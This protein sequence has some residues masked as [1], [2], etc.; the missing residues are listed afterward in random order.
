MTLWTPPVDDL[1]FVLEEVVGLDRLAALPGLSETTA[2]LA[3]AVLGEAGRFAADVL[4]PLN[5]AGDRSPPVLEAG[6]VRASPGFADAWRR[7][8]DGGWSALPFDPAHG[9]QGLPW[10]LATAVQELWQGAN[11]AFALCPMLSQAAI[12]LLAALGTPD[13]RRIFL[14]PLATGRWTGTMD[15]T[16]P[17]AGSDLSLIR[18]RAEPAPDG[19]WRLFGQKIFITWGE[20]DLAENIVH[21][22]L[23]RGAGAPEGTRG[24]SLFLVP[25]RLPGEGGSLGPPNDVRCIKLEHKLGIHASPT[26]VMAFGD[27]GGAVGWLVGEENRGLDAMFL[28]M[29]NARLAVGV[30]GFAIAERARQQAEAYALERRQGRSR[31]GKGTAAI[32]EHPDVRRMLLAM[33]ARTEAARALGLEAA[34]C[35]DVARRHPDPKARAAAEARVGLLTPVVKAWSTDIGC[36]VASLAV[37]VH[38]GMGYI[39]ET[40]AAQH[41]RDA[42]IAPIYE[43]TN[44][45]QAADLTLRKVIRDGGAAAMDFLNEIGALPEVLKATGEADLGRIAEALGDGQATLA[46]ATRWLVEETRGEDAAAAA[47]ASPY[48]RLFGLVAGGAMMARSALAAQRAARSNTHDPRFLSAKRLTARF[49]AEQILVEAAPILSQMRTGAATILSE[50]SAEA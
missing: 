8:A 22:V 16:E 27:A 3:A 29:N 11:M 45:I 49:Y 21:M 9:G 43:G 20:H 39:E 4:A 2:D 25:R 17:Q 36:E 31:T 5:A 28:M 23:A 38:G 33:R 18:T 44:G 35:L 6:G 46:A 10:V 13:Q 42:R 41:L 19:S 34:A 30:Q 32:A 50:A 47:A 37:Q 48:L 7:F 26:C 40:G 14:P 12:E 24:L 1:L 15:L